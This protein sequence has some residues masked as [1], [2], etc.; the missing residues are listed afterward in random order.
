MR[1]TLA[2]TG[3]FHFFDLARQMNRLG[4]LNFLYTAYP[5]WKIRNTDIP[6]SSIKTHPWLHTPYMASQRWQWIPEQISRN[7]DYWD[8]YYFDA[9]VAHNLTPCDVFSA[10]SSCGLLSGK[11]AHRL[12]AKY[13]C[14]RGSTHIQTQDNILREEH[15]RW[16]ITYP[17]I[18]KKI[19]SRELEEY[20]SAD[21]ITVPSQFSKNSFVTQ[22]IPDHRVAVVPYG[23]DLSLF[24]PV[25]APDSDK[26]VVTFV[27]GIN[28]RKGIP[29]LVQA[30]NRLKARNKTLH[31]IGQADT[32]LVRN[33][34][35]RSMWPENT[36]LLGH[37]PQN[38]LKLHLS[39]SDV[40][41]LPSVE[42]GF[43]LVMSQAMACGCPVIATHNTGANELIVDGQNGFIVNPR[44]VTGLVRALECIADQ[45]SRFDMR[46]HALTSVRNIGG[47]NEYGDRVLA[48]YKK[49]CSG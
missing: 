23:V 42:D 15:A 38:Q 28:L 20:E 2:A 36:R 18:D 44:D 4:A 29:Y 21:L 10:I 6:S 24:H 1:I 40:L 25:A 14:D 47:W 8:R 46:H 33:L 17:G 48:E 30:F 22:G 13:V 41:V 9:H 19:I 45:P 34:S 39:R 7:L 35:A 26:F 43:G 32:K 49:I 5:K 37:I 11:Q 3:K 27:G 31:L 12:G 16:G